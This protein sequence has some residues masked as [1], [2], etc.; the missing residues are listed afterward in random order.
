[1]FSRKSCVYSFFCCSFSES[2]YTKELKSSRFFVGAG[3]TIIGV[4]NGKFQFVEQ[5]RNKPRQL[6]DPHDFT[7]KRQRV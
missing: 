5:I 2:L 4:D 6:G 3:N 7:H 1:M